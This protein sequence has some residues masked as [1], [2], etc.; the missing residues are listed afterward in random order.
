MKFDAIVFDFDGVLVESVD[1]K[2]QA[3]ATLYSEYGRKSRRK[4]L[5][6]DTICF[7]N[8]WKTISAM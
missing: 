8:D 1:V 5:K 2:T 6:C 7:L 3:F 4:S